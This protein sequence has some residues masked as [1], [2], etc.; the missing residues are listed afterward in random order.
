MY[1]YSNCDNRELPVR[2]HSSP[3]RR[4]SDR[5]DKNVAEAL[6]RIS[7]IQITRNRGEGSSIAIRGLTQVRTE[8]NGRDSFGA[9]G[10]RALSFQDVPSGLL[11]G[12]AVSKNPPAMVLAGGVGGL[13]NLPT[14]MPV[15]KTNQN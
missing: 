4:S 7:G 11:A 14:H 10:G 12:V 9:S 13:V 6:Q 1:S 5:P 8:V 3:T 15:D 2:T